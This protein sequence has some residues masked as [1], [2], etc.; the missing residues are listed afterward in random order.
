MKALFVGRF[1]PLHKGHEEVIRKLLEEYEKIIV[2]I[3]SKEKGRTQSNPFSYEERKEM[4]E[5]VF[6]KEINDGKIV[7]DGIEDMDSDEDWTNAII[8]KHEF[9]VV[10]TGSDWVA[11]C[12]E[13]KK[14]VKRIELIN[15]E[16]LNGTNI[17][18]LM[19]E[20]SDEWKE[21]VSKEVAE[22]IQRIALK[23][24]LESLS[25]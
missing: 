6:S 9:D 12:F 2:L 5:I 11:K 4:L 10:V 17:R 15:P 13:G 21:Y 25:P 19:K 23:H 22:Y 3:G 1:Q 8:E 20:G 14:E 24:F 7:I 16:K 18:R